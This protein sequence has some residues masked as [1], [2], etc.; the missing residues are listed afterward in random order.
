MKPVKPKSYFSA[1]MKPE[2][3]FDMHLNVVGV[4][5]FSTRKTNDELRFIGFHKALFTFILLK[6]NTHC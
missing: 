1:S 2:H 6:T 5:F 4:E 3:L